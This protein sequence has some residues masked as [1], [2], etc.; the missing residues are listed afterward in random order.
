MSYGI[1]LERLGDDA[2]EMTTLYRS[3]GI[4]AAGHARRQPD[5]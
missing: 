5:L 3:L 4:H 1:F 2:R